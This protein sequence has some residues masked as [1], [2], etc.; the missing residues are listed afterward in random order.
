MKPRSALLLSALA[1]LASSWASA[2]LPHRYH[3]HALSDL[4]SARR[5]QQRRA[6]DKGQ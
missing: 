4:R 6:G 1:P 3:L 5:L 2:D